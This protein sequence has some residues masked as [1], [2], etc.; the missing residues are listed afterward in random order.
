MIADEPTGNLDP[1]K[2]KEIME[3]LEKINE[4]ENTTIVMVT[5]DSDLVN[6]YKKRT[7]ALEEGCIVSDLM[8]GGYLKHD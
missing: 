4:V 7:I 3:L 2:S 6:T 1:Q 8:E 5:H